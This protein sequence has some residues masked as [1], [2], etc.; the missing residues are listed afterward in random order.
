MPTG[1][2]AR[3]FKMQSSKRIGILCNKPSRSKMQ[4]MDCINFKKRNSTQKT[5]QNN[6]PSGSD[7]GSLHDRERKNDNML[8]ISTPNR[9]GDEGRYKRSPEAAP[10][11]YD[12]KKRKR[13]NL[14]QSILWL[15]IDNR[16]NICQPKN[17][18]TIKMQ[19]RT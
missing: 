3:E 2:N 1:S 17:S 18:F 15:Q 8:N 16:P 13:R 7:P 9:S 4:K 10:S 5:K 14:L 11:I 6:D 19:Q 12:T